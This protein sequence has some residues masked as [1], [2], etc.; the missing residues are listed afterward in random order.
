VCISDEESS[1]QLFF[2]GGRIIDIEDP[3]YAGNEFMEFGSPYVSLLEVTGDNVE[4][5]SA[6]YDDRE[7]VLRVTGIDM[8]FKL[9]IGS[10][11]TGF[12]TPPVMAEV[13]TE[14]R[15]A[16][17]ARTLEVVTWV[18][19]VDADGISSDAGD[20]YFPGDTAVRFAPPFGLSELSAD[21]TLE[22]FASISD[23]S[24]FGVFSDPETN[25][26]SLSPSLELG[27]LSEAADS[28]VALSHK[29][30]E[31]RSGEQTVWRRW[32]AAGGPNSTDIRSDF[33]TLPAF[34]IPIEE[35]PVTLS[36]SNDFAADAQWIVSNNEGD[37]ID[38][39]SLTDGEGELTLPN[40]D[41]TATP[42]SWPTN[43]QLR[44]SIS[45]DVCACLEEQDD[46]GTSVE[47]DDAGSGIE[48]KGTPAMSSGSVSFSVPTS[49]PVELP[50]PDAGWV[51]PQV[52]DADGNP[53]PAKLR[54]IGATSIQHYEKGESERFAVP[55]GTW[56]IEVS[57]GEEYSRALLEDVEV[58]RGEE[59]IIT[60]VLARTMDTTAWVSGDMHQHSNRSAD[61]EVSAVDRALSNLI[62]GVDFMGPSDH[63]IV[64]DYRGV[65]ENLGVSDRL[66]VLQGIEI[67]PTRGHMNAFPYPYDHDATS[68]GGVPLADR[69]P[70][71]LR[72]G[73]QL[74]QP[75]LATRAREY[76]ADIIQLNHA[77]GRSS[78]SFLGYVSWDPV[79]GEPTEKL[80]DWFED[81]D[82]IEIVNE[83]DNTCLLLR[84]WF[85]FLRHG[86][87]LTGMGNSDTH[88]L[89]APSGWPRNY[90]FVGEE[91]EAN[92]T[93]EALVDAIEAGQ[94]TVSGNLFVTFTDGTLPGDTIEVDD[95]TYEANLM[96]QSPT[97]AAADTLITYVNGIEVSR[98]S[99]DSETDELVDLDETVSISVSEDSFIV[100]FAI[101]SEAMSEVTPGKTAFGFT[102]PVFIDVDGGGYEA[103]GVDFEADVPIP[104]NLP[105]CGN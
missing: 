100:F 6:G 91:D 69:D 87:R 79:T 7:A 19:S 80:D 11:G 12:L 15:L 62:A 74:L 46:H 90:L 48:T 89:G 73:I 105:W 92:I 32:Y 23:E 83:L 103:P 31:L 61:S 101:D 102:N 57:L 98:T 10:L 70:D 40:G 85:A 33:E 26:K 41:Y 54:L 81:F 36:A 99:L 75:E 76:G 88:S 66:H 47:L 95:G 30:I 8:P 27:I 39:V 78:S 5:L 50:M 68:G 44:L 35:S 63:D 43:D 49:G 71:N 16:A 64:E 22:F 58:S 21:E 45:T 28:L 24:S 60:P 97:W 56:D 86:K 67:S 94:V 2:T 4:L 9:L 84:D 59:T 20:L 14:Y 42:V 104:Q 82:S 3:Q 38:M 18:H 93:D 77:R 55:A 96:I 52:E 13:E 72:D 37:A 25:G 65:V 29:D 51:V 34:P 53:I 1:N 17:D